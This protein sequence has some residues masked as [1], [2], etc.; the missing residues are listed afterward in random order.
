M[1]QFIFTAA[2]TTALAVAAPSVASAQVIVGGGYPAYYG[3]YSPYSYGTG[4]T[5]G[6]GGLIQLGLNSILGGNN[7]G[8][9]S[10]YYGGYNNYG[11]R[12]YS[13]PSYYSGYG[14][15]GYN[16]GNRG[17]GNRYWGGRRFR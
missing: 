10:D 14:N 6:N 13:Y 5:I 11:Y 16:Y 2:A 3:G 17:Y 1:R 15:R 7:Y 12:S 4:V 9:S 8:Y